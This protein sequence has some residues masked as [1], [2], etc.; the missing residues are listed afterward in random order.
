MRPNIHYRISDHWSGEVG[1]NIFIGEKDHTFF[2]QF[3]DDTNVYFGLR[4]S[5]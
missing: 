5:F 2:G 4:W 3:K 1:A